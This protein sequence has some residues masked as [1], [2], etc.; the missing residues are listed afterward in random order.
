MV[1]QASPHAKRELITVKEAAERS[2]WSPAY[3]YR[4]FD[5]GE[6]QGVRGGRSVRLYV[7]SLEAWITRNSR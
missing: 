3:L 6:I 1:A 7:D 4:L 5:R 2:S